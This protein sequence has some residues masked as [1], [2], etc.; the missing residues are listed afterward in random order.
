[1]K[2]ASFNDFMS[3]SYTEDVLY[4][5]EPLSVSFCTDTLWAKRRQY[6]SAASVLVTLNWRHHKV[7]RL[8][9]QHVKQYL[10]RSLLVEVL[11]KLYNRLTSLFDK[12]LVRGV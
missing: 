4:S 9:V 5:L 8:D 11:V 10:P 3:C 2:Y 12:L 1:M 7:Q 6:Y